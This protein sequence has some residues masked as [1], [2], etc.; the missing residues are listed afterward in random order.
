MP[1][2]AVWRANIR[3]KMREPEHMCCKRRNPM[4]NP[5]AVRQ[6]CAISATP[7]NVC[8]CICTGVAG[9]SSSL[10]GHVD[11]EKYIHHV[12]PGY[13]INGFFCPPT[14]HRPIARIESRSFASMMVPAGSM[15]LLGSTCDASLAACSIASIS[16]LQAC[17]SRGQM[18]MGCRRIISRA[19]LN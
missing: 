9:P 12:R 5:N 2:C 18:T 1:R 7:P 15:G 13:S 6:S 17:W 8:C 3:L 11:H 10:S 16:S 4:P 19:P 14:V